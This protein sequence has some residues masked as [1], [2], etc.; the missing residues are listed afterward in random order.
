[1]MVAKWIPVLFWITAVY[2]SVLGLVFLL[3]PGYPF[4]LFGVTPPNH[5]GY[6]QFPAALLLIF[7]FLFF[8]IARNPLANRGL[9]VYGILFK[10]AY[11]GVSG[12]Y[13][14]VTDLPAMWKPF[15]LADLVMGL[16]FI[17]A[18]RQLPADIF[19]Q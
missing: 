4:E 3:S 10:A 1:M 13:W 16:L 12:W 18:Y 15:T 6:V 8:N 7:A 2:D 9:I 19:G 14:A 17:L 5:M 11:C